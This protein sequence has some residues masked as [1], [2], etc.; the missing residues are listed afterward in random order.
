VCDEIKNFLDYKVGHYVHYT[1]IPLRY[2]KANILSSFMFIK[3]K[4]KPDGRYDKTKARLVGDGSTQAKHMY[5]F[6]A[7]TTI[8][9]STVFIL[10]NI[11][12]YYRCELVSYDIKGAFLHASFTDKDEPTYIT[13]RKEVVD[14]WVK[15][16]PT[17]IPFVNSRGDLILLLDK[18]V[19]G[20]KQSP[21]KFQQHLARTLISLGYIRCEFDDCVYV[22]VLQYNLYPCR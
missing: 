6:T 10:F 7:S 2:R 11:A 22:R 8:S 13:I 5:E 19:Y 14:I 17:S 18:F 1:D 20:L 16:D 15:L 9:L 3:H 12:S 4:M 21:I